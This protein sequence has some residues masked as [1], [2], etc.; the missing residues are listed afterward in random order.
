MIHE[1]SGRELS[2]MKRGAIE[3]CVL[4]LLA[5]QS[6]YGFE[7]V[8]RLD[9]EFGLNVSEGTIYPLLA[10]LRRSQFVSTFWSTSAEGPPRRYYEVTQ[11]G[12]HALTEFIA[13]WTSFVKSVE[14][15]LTLKGGI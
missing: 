4:A 15:I 9:R 8:T 6:H 3:F 2:Q 12:Q 11:Q 1:S 5:Q 14:S 7:L 10:R 13:D